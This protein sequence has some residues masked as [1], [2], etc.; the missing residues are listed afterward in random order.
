MLLLMMMMIK[1]MLTFPFVHNSWCSAWSSWCWSGG[2][3]D[4]DGSDDHDHDHDHD[5]IMIW[6]SIV[7]CSHILSPHT[8]CSRKYKF[9]GNL[10][11]CPNDITCQYVGWELERIPPHYM[12]FDPPPIPANIYRDR[13]PMM[14]ICNFTCDVH[15]LSSSVWQFSRPKDCRFGEK[16][17]N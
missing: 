10:S 2:G 16:F 12:S 3:D 6:H 7:V 15:F 14:S 17:W 5:L 8:E 4:D 11:G 13:V 9:T 1:P